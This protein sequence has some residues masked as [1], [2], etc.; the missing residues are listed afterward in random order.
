MTND[1]P[2]WEPNWKRR[3]NSPPDDLIGCFY[4]PAFA[5]ACSYDRAVGFFSSTLLAEI[6]PS[7]DKFVVNGGTIR[8]IT[9]PANL[10]DDDLEAMGKGEKFRL[11]LEKDLKTAIS[12][13]IPSQVL[14]DRLKLLTWMVAARKLEVR[15]A[16]R[17]HPRCYSLFHEKI[18]VFTDFNQN[19]MTFTGSPNETIGGARRHSESFPLHRSWAGEEQRLYSIDERDRFDS[20]W[21]KK[22]DGIVTW[23]V[24]E[25]IEEPMRSAFGIREPTCGLELP[26][27]KKGKSIPLIEDVHPSATFPA[28]DVSLTPSLPANLELREYQ[29]GAVN[30]W[31]EAS[32]RGTFAMATGTGKTITA[33][34]AATQASL[35]VA[36]QNLPLLVLVVVPSIDLVEQWRSD[37]EWF[38][39]RSAICHGQLTSRQR[40]DLKSA[41][42]AARSTYGRRTEMVITTAGSLTPLGS[43]TESEHFLQRQLSRHT[44]NLLVIGDE[45]HSLGTGPRLAALPK[46]PTFTLGLSATPKRHGDE[47]G[48]EALLAYF[49]EPVISINIKSAI[50]DYKALVEYDYH[51][52]QIQLTPDEAEK[53]RAISARIAAAFAAGDEERAEQEIRRRTRLTQHAAN[54]QVELRQL[55]ASGL[56]HENQQIIYVAE[57]ANPDTDLRQLDET[58]RMLRGE[59]GMKVERY[60]GETESSRR[61]ALQRRLADGEIQALLAMKCLDEGVDIPSVRIGIITASTQNPRQFV[62]RRGRL[63]R[64]DPVNPKSHAVI[65]DFIVMPPRVDGTPSDS[66]KRLVGAELGRAAELA[67]AARN[68]EVMFHIIEWAYDHQLDPVTFPWMSLSE[69][70]EMEEWIP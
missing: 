56:R 68:R 28:S 20:I 57:G 22:V 48:T 58:E 10:T 69:S 40:A 23:T 15:I 35:H 46:T 60:Y 67:D 4:V 31:L 36:R 33:L 16:L 12:T 5:R 17:E 26:K 19:W 49:G 66:E 52:L 59:F 18:G 41:F 2:S 37:A 39:F 54:K 25:W 47:V 8:L 1:L 53:Y 44:G 70:E 21:E 13:N 30:D 29:R 50:Y 64:H 45:M 24:N 51:P 38:G 65:Y 14:T 6:A 9:S 34:S 61:E 27:P 42:S 63:L 11:R 43:T 7:I 55:M 3:Y 62:Q 32:G